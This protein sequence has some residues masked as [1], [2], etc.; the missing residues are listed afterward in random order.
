MGTIA[1]IVESLVAQRDDK[2]AKLRSRFDEHSNWLARELDQ[3]RQL[4]TPTIERRLFPSYP[5]FTAPIVAV[6]PIL[7]PKTS[8]AS[9]AGHQAYS[10]R[11]PRLPLPKQRDPACKLCSSSL[12]PQSTWL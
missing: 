6:V 2:A 7:A 12:K 1:K 11:G 8:H 9:S 5:H 4:A 10:E 3:V